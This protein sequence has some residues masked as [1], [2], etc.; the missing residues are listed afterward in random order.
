MAKQNWMDEAR[1]TVVNEYQEI[2]RRSMKSRAV[3]LGEEVLSAR[4]ARTRF[5]NMSPAEKQRIIQERG[6]DSV[7]DLFGGR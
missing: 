1:Q 6:V 3:P 2:K 7:L 4:D 5:K